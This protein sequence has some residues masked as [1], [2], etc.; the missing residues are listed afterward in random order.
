MK[1]VRKSEVVN[2]HV[3]DSRWVTATIRSSTLEVEFGANC[4][5]DVCDMTRYIC[6]VMHCV[7]TTWKW[8]RKIFRWAGIC[9]T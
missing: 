5:E 7:S 4:L 9:M 6:D 8:L 1:L 3:E 2:A